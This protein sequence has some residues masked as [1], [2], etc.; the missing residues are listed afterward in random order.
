[1][2]VDCHAHIFPFL[3]GPS[4]YESA[5]EHLRWLQLYVT[6]HGQPVKELTT[7]RIVTDPGLA[8]LPIEGPQSLN[9]VGFRVGKNG[10]F[11][12]RSDGRDLYIH[13][14][15]PSLQANEAPADYL[16]AEMAY[17]G[18]DIAV[19]QNAHLYGYLDEFFS[20]A[21]RSHREKF[22]GLAQV[23]EAGADKNEEISK[24]EKAV[25][26]L[27]LRGLY[28]ANRAYYKCGY[29]FSYDDARFEGLWDTVE[30]LGIPVFWEVSAV[31]LGG[32]MSVVG[33]I[34]RLLRWADRHRDIRCVY[35]HGLA[36]ELL[37][38]ELAKPVADLTRR[39]QF[40]IEVLYP[41]SW[42]RGHEYPY[43]ELEPTIRTLYRLVGSKR[44]IW[45]SDMPNV[46]RNCTY[47]QAL[48]YLRKALKDVA[49]AREVD[50]ILG[51]NVLDLFAETA[52]DAR[53]SHR[54]APSQG[55]AWSQ[56]GPVH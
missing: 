44:L 6:G 20:H 27:G 3:G 25:N 32:K 23:D 38:G 28:F 53:S 34:A 19:L 8:N 55:P 11:L 1:M 36:P 26:E 37:E 17:A 29:R 40:L 14:M 31:P 15:P 30:R 51:G 54:T 46:Q 5:D 47:R 16:L 41:I 35:T 42:G 49:P 56:R 9:D 43:A 22:I 2:I 24:L 7:D 12:W 33:E 4:G 18:V 13:F 50:G 10:R 48:D 45:G 21:V 52:Q 39:E